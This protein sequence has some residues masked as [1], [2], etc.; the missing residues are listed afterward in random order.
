MNMADKETNVKEP[1]K[2]ETI[3]ETPKLDEVNDEEINSKYK[4]QY[5]KKYKDKYKKKYKDYVNK[6]NTKSVATPEEE[7]LTDD[8]K[9]KSFIDIIIDFILKMCAI[10]TVFFIIQL[11]AVV[12]NA[13]V[14]AFVGK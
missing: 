4:E 11:V 2:E 12:F 14:H 13:I 1:I 7:S 9:D 10:F 6:L 8:S 5:K 3:K